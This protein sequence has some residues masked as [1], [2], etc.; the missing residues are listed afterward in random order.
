MIGGLM[1]STSLYAM[2]AA[3]GLALSMGSANAADLGG[4]C[5]AD[6]EERIAELE[7]TTV[8]KGNR[9]VSLTISGQVNRAT[10][11]WDDGVDRNTYFGLDNTNSSSRIG[12]AGNAKI[13]AEWSAG[14][15]ILMDIADKA[16]TASVSNNGNA[17][18]GGSFGA[19]LANTVNGDHLL[20]V[21]DANW[22]IQSDRLGR[23]T[24]GRLT[25]SGA[26]AGIDLAGIQVVASSSPGL[27]GGGLFWR[28]PNGE[29]SNLN[30]NNTTDGGGYPTT[31][32]EGVKW[33]S[34]TLHGFVVS[35][36]IAE[37]G[38]VEQYKSLTGSGA[39]NLS[40]TGRNL[41]IDLRYA[42]EF[43]GVRVAFGIGY[44]KF[45]GNGD[46]VLNNP[47][48]GT[49]S[50]AAGNLTALESRQW[51]ISGALMHVP[52]GL[53]IQG[54]YLSGDH[55]ST[56]FAGAREAK[57]GIVQA[58]LVRNF[59]GIGNTALYG[60][61]G[62][63][64]GWATARGIELFAAAPAPSGAAGTSL[65]LMTSDQVTWWGLGAVQ[66]IDAAAMDLYAGYRNFSGEGTTT[67]GTASVKDISILTVGARI[68]F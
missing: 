17:E 68:R 24:V 11:F 50:S 9:K 65:G 20:R 28:G 58:G 25:T 59:F 66:T 33:T 19:P 36:S 35:A 6:L 54:D 38:S 18:D 40:T 55:T 53:F 32:G 13:N 16:R 56:A 1:K 7:A 62:R 34:P 46:G 60:E 41:G 14:F 30:I 12:F 52:T 29:V 27:I 22:W 23:M 37:A 8:R 67:F 42:N 57:R 15:S 51:G 4:N 2:V 47:N 45:E 49:T 21:R 31:R 3:A 26:V 63:A 48:S 44:E 61:Y 10:M 39:A 64:E 5:C 43:N